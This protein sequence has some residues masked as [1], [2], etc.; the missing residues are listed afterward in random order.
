[1]TERGGGGDWGRGGKGKRARG[2]SPPTYRTRIVF[3]ERR[4]FPVFVFVVLFEVR[5]GRILFTA[6]A[7]AAAPLSFAFFL[8]IGWRSSFVHVVCRIFILFVSVL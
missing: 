5:C 2:R 8:R 4:W 3:G 6:A 7:A 1:M